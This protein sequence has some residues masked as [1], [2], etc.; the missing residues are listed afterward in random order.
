[1][2]TGNGQ[3]DNGALVDSRLIADVRTLIAR[4]DVMVL[5]GC[6]GGRPWGPHAPYGEHPICDAVDL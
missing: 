4:D 5:P 2:P 1:V 3:P 6:G